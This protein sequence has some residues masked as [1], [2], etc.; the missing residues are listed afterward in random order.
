MSEWVRIFQRHTKTESHYAPQCHL[1]KNA[2]SCR[3]NSPVSLSGWRIPAGKLF[4]S[5]GP[6]AA[7]LRSPIIAVVTVGVD[8]SNT[9][10]QFTNWTTSNN[11]YKLL[12]QLGNVGRCVLESPE[13][14]ELCGRILTNVGVLTPRGR[15]RDYIPGF[16]TPSLPSVCM[17]ECVDLLKL[18]YGLYISCTVA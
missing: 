10:S 12:G 1:N 2:F 7:K 17:T 4:Q 18:Y 16:R 15:D 6:A 9:C 5:R 13:W 3:R 14:A 8:V 11:W